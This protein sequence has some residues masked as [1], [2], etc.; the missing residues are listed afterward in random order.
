MYKIKV[1]K[2]KNEKRE[3]MGSRVILLLFFLEL[4]SW[5]V[6]II[7]ALHFVR[8]FRF[9]G[10]LSIFFSEAINLDL[11]NGRLVIFT[12]DFFTAQHISQRDW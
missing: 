5:R 1:S 8:C 12:D 10:H 2:S 3:I 7:S 4:L 6:I 11:E 9:R